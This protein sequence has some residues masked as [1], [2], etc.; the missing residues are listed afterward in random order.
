MWQAM[1][2]AISALI[3]IN[4]KSLVRFGAMAPSDPSWIPI[5]PRLPN[6]HSRYVDISSE[7]T[8][9]YTLTQNFH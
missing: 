5:A 6:P 7:R 3:T 1:L 2:P 8:Y 4:A 9:R